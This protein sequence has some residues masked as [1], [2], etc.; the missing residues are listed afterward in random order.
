M[1]NNSDC[2]D[3]ILYNTRKRYA[4]IESLD[5]MRNISWLASC[6]SKIKKSNKHCSENQSA[7]AGVRILTRFPIFILNSLNAKSIL[8]G[9]K[10]VATYSIS[11]QEYYIIFYMKQKLGASKSTY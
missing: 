8:A 5:L 3:V 7:I 6:Y 1:R 2:K 11:K 4:V 10:L 9:E